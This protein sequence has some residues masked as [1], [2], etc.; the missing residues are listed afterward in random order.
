MPDEGQEQSIAERGAR[1]APRPALAAVGLGL[2]GVATARPAL[3]RRP[4]A[5]GRR[6]LGARPVA[7]LV[8]P[9]DE[10]PAERPRAAGIADRRADSLIVALFAVGDRR[11]SSSRSPG[12][13]SASATAS[14]TAST[15]RRPSRLRPAVL[16][17]RRRQ[18]ARSTCRTSARHDA[19]RT[20]RRTSAS[21]SCASSSRAT[22]RSRSTRTPR[23]ATCYV[24]GQH[25]DGRNAAVQT[26]TRR[27]ARDRREASAPAG[28]TWCGRGD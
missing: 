19:R 7:G 25:D 23:S 26:G 17:A 18:P 5:G 15:H 22:P 11:R 2:V 12:S 28:S 6:R 14:A 16:Q 20:S 27:P 9:L 24:L 8:D 13:T 21:A 4:L 10:P 3:A 1:R